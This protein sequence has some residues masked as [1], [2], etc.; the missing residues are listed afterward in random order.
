MNKFR[1]ITTGAQGTHSSVRDLVRLAMVE[2]GVSLVWGAPDFPAPDFIKIEAQSLIDGDRNQ[3]AI[4]HGGA[5]LR[6]A[7]AHKYRTLY[8]LEYDPE[9]MVTVTCGATEATA[10]TL[11]AVVA[12]ASEVILFD[13]GYDVGNIVRMAGGVPV[14]VPLDPVDFTIDCALLEQAVSERT[15][16]IVINSPHNP[17]GR[18]FTQAELQQLADF[19]IRHDLIAITD[20][21]YEHMVYDGVHIPLATLPGMAERTVT[22]SS[23]SKVFTITGWRVGFAAAPAWLTA[24]I[25]KTHADLTAGAPAPL[26]EACVRGLAV[27]AEF[28][29][30]LREEYRARRNLLFDAL[31][32]AG[33]RPSLP[34]GALFILADVTQLAGEDE[35]PLAHWLSTELG[36]AGAPGSVFFRRQG[37]RRFLRFTFARATR[38]L[39]DAAQRLARA[40]ELLPQ[41]LA[42]RAGPLGTV[43]VL[44]A[45]TVG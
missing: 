38:T 6:S 25:R 24:A 3:Y 19:C 44:S 9:S 39:E 31:S 42:S 28:Y 33:L 41:F 20:E 43:P 32:R 16:A 18:V 35:W 21:V 27:G 8:G 30:T 23:F 14:Y 11:L 17:T 4:P 40:P 12:P 45:M 1:K 37:P 22:I 29:T 15:V 10:S 5:A 7:I 13:P 34:Q 26:Q 36:V 2:R